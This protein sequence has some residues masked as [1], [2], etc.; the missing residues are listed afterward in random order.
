[1]MNQK[2]L[3]LIMG[4]LLII[5]LIG[6]SVT[7][8]R[9]GVKTTFN[10]RIAINKLDTAEVN[11]LNTIV[12]G[13]GQVQV[14]PTEGE[15]ILVTLE[16]KGGR[17]QIDKKFTLTTEIEKSKLTVH[18]E[19]N[20]FGF[21]NFSFLSNLLQLTVYLPEKQY[22]S[23]TINSD[24]GE[25]RVD[26]IQTRELKVD[27]SVG[28]IEIDQMISETTKLN[29][30]VGTITVNHLEG[31]LE[32]QVNVGKVKLSSDTINQNIDLQVDVGSIEVELDNEP[33]NVMF[34][35][36]IDLGSTKLFGDTMSSKL[37]GSGE[38]LVNL[39]A[40][41]GDITVRQK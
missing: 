32:A 25:V 5:G 29:S 9:D 15:E 7:N 37:I 35:T 14:R 16:G 39:S 17:R 38:N 22:E 2:R 40:N 31:S 12:E 27:V 13:I 33:E 6:S 20:Q 41:I 21:F 18:L 19:Y 23:L 4:I 10:D 24:V 30:N 36:A 11:A 8:N 26:Q 34:S 3:T 28:S 1:M